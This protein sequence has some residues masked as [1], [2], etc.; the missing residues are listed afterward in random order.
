VYIASYFELQPPNPK[1]KYDSWLLRHEPVGE[2]MKPAIEKLQSRVDQ[3]KIKDCVI[4]ETKTFYRIEES[5]K[6]A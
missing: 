3:G 2:R 4:W 5:K 6:K 1:S